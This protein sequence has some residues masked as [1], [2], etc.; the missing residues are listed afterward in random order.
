MSILNTVIEG[1]SLSNLRLKQLRLLWY[2]S[3]D[4]TRKLGYQPYDT[5]RECQRFVRK[6]V[7]KSNLSVEK[8]TS[9]GYIYPTSV[10]ARMSLL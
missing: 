4:T 3:Y 8:L 2:Q 1:Q 5:I 7:H 6:L 10:G 9:N